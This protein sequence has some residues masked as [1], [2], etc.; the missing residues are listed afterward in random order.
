MRVD[1]G[2]HAML[3]LSGTASIGPAGETLHAGDFEAQALRMYQNFR[4]LLRAEGADWANVVKLTVYLVDMS[5]YDR[6]NVV[7]KRYFDDLG[8]HPYPASTGIE[9]KLCRPE[10][11]IEMDGVAVV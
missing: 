9:A 2:T 7:R 8:V 11:M 1:F 10:L 3:Y 5:L 6:F 4:A